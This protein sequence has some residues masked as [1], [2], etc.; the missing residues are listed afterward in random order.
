MGL[1][2]V[3]F[4][5]INKDPEIYDPNSG[6]SKM[7]NPQSARQPFDE[8]YTGAHRQFQIVTSLSIAAIRLIRFGATTHATDMDQRSVGLSFTPVPI[9]NGP[10]YSVTAPANANIAPPGT[11]CCLC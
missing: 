3:W 7:T 11:I 1:L 8:L 5:S 6:W 9:Q 4:I 10:T 2:G